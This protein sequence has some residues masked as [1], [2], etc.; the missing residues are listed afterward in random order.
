M[1]EP[2]RARARNRDQERLRRC[3][4]GTFVPRTYVPDARP[5]MAV[6]TKPPAALGR[7]HHL[8]RTGSSTIAL[9]FHAQHEQQ[10]RY[11]A[12]QQPTAAGVV[13][14]FRQENIA[15]VRRGGGMPHFA[16]RGVRTCC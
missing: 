7:S 13:C 4:E 2:P 14:I 10:Q 9:A 1:A 12:K 6:H 3:D 11:H 16:D 8:L 15:G 5:T